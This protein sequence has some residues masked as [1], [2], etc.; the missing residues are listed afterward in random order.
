MTGL[1]PSVPTMITRPLGA[2][3]VVIV[4][5]V[6]VTRSTSARR[7]F[8]ALTTPGK[9]SALTN[10]GAACPPVA[11]AKLPFDFAKATY[12]VVA[13]APDPV[14]LVCAS[15]MDEAHAIATIAENP[16]GIDVMVENR[17]RRRS[18]AWAAQS[19]HMML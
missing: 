4:G 8:T 6:P 19:H 16:G 2:P 12:D 18:N 17:L 14:A 13:A 15:A 3:D 10:S 11:R 7:S 1:L 5:A 9:S